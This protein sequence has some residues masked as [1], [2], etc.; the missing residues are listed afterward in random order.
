MFCVSTEVFLC[1]LIKFHTNKITSHFQLLHMS[2][3][4]QS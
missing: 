4:D 3:V 1:K 2:K